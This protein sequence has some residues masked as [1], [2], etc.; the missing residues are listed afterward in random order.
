MVTENKYEIKLQKSK[1]HKTLVG[2]RLNNNQLHFIDVTPTIGYFTPKI[3][4]DCMMLIDLDIS[5]AFKLDAQDFVECV[6]F[7]RNLQKIV[8]D[9]CVQFSRSQFRQMFKYLL[10]MQSISLQGCIPL[11]FCTAYCVISYSEDMNYFNFE[12]THVGNIADWRRFKAIFFQVKLGTN[13]LSKFPQNL[14]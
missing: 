7:A 4:L 12:P 6:V 8:M 11:D 9:R 5:D 13:F 3:L 2:I 14:K 1:R 10:K